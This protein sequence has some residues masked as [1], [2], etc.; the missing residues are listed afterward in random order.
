MTRLACFLLSLLGGGSNVSESSAALDAAVATYMRDAYPE[1][2]ANV[3]APQDNELIVCLTA[4]KVKLDNFW[5]VIPSLAH[6]C[7]LIC[8]LVIQG[9][10]LALCVARCDRFRLSHAVRLGAVVLSPVS[11]HGSHRRLRLQVKTTVHYFENG[12]VQ[13]NTNFPSELTVSFTVRSLH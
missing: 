6:V 8:F 7:V 10:P 9:G 11:D 4:Q 12:N 13:L 1:G 5:C 2:L 3:F